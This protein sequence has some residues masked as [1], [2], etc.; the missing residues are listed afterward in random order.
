M[1]ALTPQQQR[2]EAFLQELEN[3]LNR[4]QQLSPQNRLDISQLTQVY[5]LYGVWRQQHEEPLDNSE[6]GLR[7]GPLLCSDSEQ[8]ALFKKSWQSHWSQFQQNN[9]TNIAEDNSQNPESSTESLTSTWYEKPKKLINQRLKRLAL[10]FMLV[11][12]S[13]VVGYWPQAYQQPFVVVPPPPQ[14]A[15]KPDTSKADPVAVPVNL[16]KPYLKTIPKRQPPPALT[17]NE[18][19]KQQLANMRYFVLAGASAVIGLVIGLIWWLRRVVFQ[20]HFS[21]A[22]DEDQLHLKLVPQTTD[23]ELIPGFSTVLAKLRFAKVGLKKIHW[24]KTLAATVRRGGFP[25]LR[26][27]DRYRQ[28]D[29][30]LLTDSRHRYDQTAWLMEKLNQTLV[31]AQVR[32]HK[33]DFDRHPDWLWPE[34]NRTRKPLQLEQILLR[35]PNSRVL[36]VSE[37]DVLFYRLTGEIQDWLKRLHQHANYQLGLL[38]Q[39]D[40]EQQARLQQGHYPYRLLNRLSDL[41]PLLDFSKPEDN[42]DMPVLPDFDSDW[43]GNSQPEDTQAV[44]L[45]LQKTIGDDGLRLLQAMA[46]Y[47]KL[48]GELTLALYQ[49]FTDADPKTP[50]P[51]LTPTALLKTVALPWCRQGWLPHWLRQLLL[52]KM[53]KIDYQHARQFFI[54]LF[55]SKNPQTGKALR[56]DIQKP[57]SFWQ[58]LSKLWQRQ[59]NANYN[60]PMRDQ[61]FTRILL[62]PRNPLAQLP[63]LGRL[64]NAFPKAA[65]SAWAS[66][67]ALT[68]LTGLLLAVVFGLWLWQGESRYANHLLD[69]KQQQHGKIL[70]NIRYHPATEPLKEIIGAGLAGLGYQVSQTVDDTLTANQITAPPSLINEISNAATYLSWGIDFAKISEG[71]QVRIEL[72]TMPQTGQVFRDKNLDL[73]L[74]KNYFPN[75][76]NWQSVELGICNFSTNGA[77]LP[78][79]VFGRLINTFGQLTDR[80]LSNGIVINSKEGNDIHVVKEGRIA[81]A[82]QLQGY[83]LLIIVEHGSD[84]MTLYAFNKSIYKKKGDWVNNGEVIASVGKIN[85]IGKQGL[86]FELR[87]KGR[88]IDPLSN[89]TTPTYA[90]IKPIPPKMVNILAGKFLMGSPENEKRYGWEGPQHLVKIAYN[91]ELSETEIT[92]AQYDQFAQATGRNLSSDQGWR[93]NDHPVINVSFEDA[94]AYTQWLSEQTGKQYRLPTEAEWE[95]GARAGTKTAYWWGETIGDNNSVCYSCGSQWDGKQTA[96]VK[97]FKANLFGLYDTAGNVLEWTQDCWHDDYHNAPKDGSV[98]LNEN[99]GDCARRV[100]RGG[101]WYDRNPLNLRTAHRSKYITGNSGSDV[102][103]RIAR[104]I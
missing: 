65:L 61:V 75:S 14:K 43:L 30:V 76:V 34:G 9:L 104:T 91:F 29:F 36:L 41:T 20:S 8:Q 48:D 37:H 19:E 53:A 3:F 47:P 45:W 90:S 38:S 97:S 64:M 79:P 56:L 101:S 52:K 86:Y 26:Y 44:L 102:G 66:V 78:M 49:W 87:R 62:W 95:Y 88:P 57:A 93:R 40:S 55:D 39:P 4:W 16:E 71:E 46:M 94:S 73:S 33:F 2:W 51:P 31:K 17:L 32:V 13:L 12:L 103:F 54:K 15:P 25:Q 28:V 77:K 58:R 42:Q 98:W 80:G 72:A 81:Y 11:A 70:V 67:L 85:V 50:K 7:L 100:I 22:P 89:C 23:S 18:E 84:Y 69:L 92:F 60:S 74:L 5:R 10:L 59:K 63:L 96:P 68:G 27:R 6:Y 83:G 82:G 35:H 24:G 1:S 21:R 99:Q